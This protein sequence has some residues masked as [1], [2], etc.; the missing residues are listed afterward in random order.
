[1]LFLPGQ[2]KRL[3]RSPS[4][5]RIWLTQLPCLFWSEIAGSQL[6]NNT[7]SVLLLCV[8]LKASVPGHMHLGENS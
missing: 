1:M 5:F 7:T 4:G 8:F 3:I 6:C 2:V